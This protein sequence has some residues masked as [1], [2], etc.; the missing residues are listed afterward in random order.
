MTLDAK[1]SQTVEFTVIENTVGEHQLELADVKRE[2]SVVHGLR[3]RRHWWLIG[4][5]AGAV[6]LILLGVFIIRS[7]QY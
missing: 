3:R 4:A 2:F 5:I 1:A 7:R 6:V